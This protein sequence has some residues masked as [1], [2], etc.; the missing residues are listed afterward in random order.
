MAY[1]YRYKNRAGEAVYIG[2]TK[3]L[4]S[5]HYAHTREPWYDKDLI[6]EWVEG[7]SPAEA[8]ILETHFISVDNPKYNKA[9]RWGKSTLTISGNFEWKSPTDAYKQKLIEL[10]CAVAEFEH[11][12]AMW[13]L[14]WHDTANNSTVTNA[15]TDTAVSTVIC[16]RTAGIRA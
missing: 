12:L 10:L 6:L 14:E 8:D 7:L 4:V 16:G 1:V 3:D 13:R 15:A 11:Q 9:K 2:K 5:R